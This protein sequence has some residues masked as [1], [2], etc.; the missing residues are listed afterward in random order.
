MKKTAKLTIQ[1]VENR[2]IPTFLSESAL[3]AARCTTT[4]CTTCTCTSSSDD[5]DTT[6]NDGN[7]PIIIGPKY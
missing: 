4:T 7:G 6:I 2:N 1:E 3:A 5:D